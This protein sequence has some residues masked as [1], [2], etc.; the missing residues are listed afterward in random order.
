[1]VENVNVTFGHRLWWVDAFIGDA[2]RGNPAAVV[3]LESPVP[4][5]QLQQIAF[6]LG[7]SETAFVRRNGD[8]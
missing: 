7:V 3:L 6:E 2:E 8:Q 1:M 5:E 4:D